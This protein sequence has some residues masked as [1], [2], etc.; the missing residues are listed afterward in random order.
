MGR[1]MVRQGSGKRNFCFE[2]KSGKSP[3]IFTN[4][5]MKCASWVECKMGAAR[6]CFPEFNQT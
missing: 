5:G 6:P 4:P 1:G 3:K 2:K